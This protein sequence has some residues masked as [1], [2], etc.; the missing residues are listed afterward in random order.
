VATMEVAGAVT[1][2]GDAGHDFDDEMDENGD[3]EPPDLVA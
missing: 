1:F 3:E 2:E